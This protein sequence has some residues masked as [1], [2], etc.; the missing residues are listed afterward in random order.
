M[1]PLNCKN[2]GQKVKTFCPVLLNPF[3][4]FLRAVKCRLPSKKR[5]RVAASLLGSQVTSGGKIAQRAV[6][7]TMMAMKGMTPL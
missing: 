4:A 6:T 2:T 5:H 7:M 3:R 1:R